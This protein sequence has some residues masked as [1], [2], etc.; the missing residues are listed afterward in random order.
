LVRQ[1]IEAAIQEA[2][3]E[4]AGVEVEMAAAPPPLLQISVRP[5]MPAPGP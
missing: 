3:P 5:G 1:V 2:A 4:V